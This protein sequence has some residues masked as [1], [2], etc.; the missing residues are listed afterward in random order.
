MSRITERISTLVNQQLPEFVS[1]EHSI[2]VSFLEAYYRFLEQDQS[3]HEIIQN[4]RLYADIDRTSSSFI[5]YFLANYGSLIPTDVLANKQILIKRLK[6]LYTAKGSELSYKALFRVLYNTEV[7][8]RYPYENVLR[9][10][11]GVWNQQVSIR[12]RKLNGSISG[13]L[14]RNLL[15]VKNSIT[16]SASITRIKVLSSDLYE[17]FIKARIIPSYS[18]D[19]IVYV[20]DDN[21]EMFKGYVEPTPVDY[22]IVYGGSGFR[23]GQIIVINLSGAVGTVVQITGVSGT[24]GITKLKFISYGY[25]FPKE[26]ITVDI[27]NDLT[28]AGR[29]LTTTTTTNGFNESVQ[30]LLQYTGT[31]PDRY[32][33]TD[34]VEIDYNGELLFSQNIDGYTPGGSTTVS[35][36][37]DP[38]VASIEFLM[39]AVG[40]YPGQFLSNKG[41]L[42][43]PDVRLQDDQLY[44]PYAYQLQTDLD[45]TKFYNIVKALAHPAGM[46]M[47]N[48]RII[49]TTSD[50]KSSVMVTHQSATA[51]Y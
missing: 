18:V 21:V 46:S 11:D 4:A 17:V 45:I 35:A 8:V 2:F 47:F 29:A 22:R 23:L 14:N 19:D 32:F 41:F 34:Y 27:F 9:A 33:L 42:S 50:I 12:V 1:S 31:E 30:V 15:L 28:I 26:S 39:G 13:V 6:D 38:S 37:G 3:A 7:S 44:Q 20:L 40:R 24:G 49:S 10:S 48:N 51:A 43:E 5:Q 16:Y 25:N 36:S